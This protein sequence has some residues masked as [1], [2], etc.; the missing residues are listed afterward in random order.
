MTG[1]AELLTHISISIMPVTVGSCRSIRSE[2]GHTAP[3]GM[4]KGCSGPERVMGWSPISSHPYSLSSLSAP[5]MRGAAAQA[6]Q[7]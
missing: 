4:V 6:A 1:H 7:H 3:P 2:G 5:D